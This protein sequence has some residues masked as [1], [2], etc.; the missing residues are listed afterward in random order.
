M[1]GFISWLC[2]LWSRPRGRSS[3]QVELRHRVEELQATVN[4]MAADLKA[5]LQDPAGQNLDIHI[6]K[7]FIDK[8]NLDQLHFNI[9]EIGVKDLSGSLSIGLNYGG[10][11]IRLNPYGIP[12][13]PPGGDGKPHRPRPLAGGQPRIRFSAGTEEGDNHEQRA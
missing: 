13:S 4:K 7:V 9:D 5:I 2:E 10:K 11:V 3:E 8:V 12:G 1:F 6:D